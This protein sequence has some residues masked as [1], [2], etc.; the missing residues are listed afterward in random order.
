MHP[1]IF[2]ALILVGAIGLFGRKKAMAEKKPSPAKKVLT[3]AKKEAKIDNVEKMSSTDSSSLN[4]LDN[5][6]ENAPE[7]LD[8]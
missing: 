8:D 6:G 5:L 4:D 3:K 7:K 2:V 1:A